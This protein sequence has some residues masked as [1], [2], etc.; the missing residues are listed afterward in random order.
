VRRSVDAVLVLDKFVGTNG[1]YA[2]FRMLAATHN[3][4]VKWVSKDD[5]AVSPAERVTMGR[6]GVELHAFRKRKA[7]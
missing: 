2:D 7:G 1:D 6:E 4:A 5:A 3:F